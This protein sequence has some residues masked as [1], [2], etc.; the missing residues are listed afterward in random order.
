LDIDNEYKFDLNN[1]YNIEV[2]SY[3]YILTEEILSPIKKYT[4]IDKDG[5]FIDIRLS[6]LRDGNKPYIFSIA[7][8]HL[9]YNL[10]KKI[11]DSNLLFSNIDNKSIIVECTICGYKF[12]Y[13]TNNCN[14]KN[15]S[16]TRKS[17]ELSIE[18]YSKKISTKNKN[19]KVINIYNKNG[20]V[21]IDYI[22]QYCGLIEYGKQVSYLFKEEYVGCNNCKVER[23]RTSQSLNIESVKKNIKNINPNINILSETYKNARTLMKCECNICN[24]IWNPSYDSMR[25]GKGCPKCANENMVNDGGYNKTTAIRNKEAWKSIKSFVYVV[26]M[27]IG[28]DIFYK[29][30]IT[31]PNTIKRRFSALKNICDTMDILMIIEDNLFNSIFIEDDLHIMFKNKKY[32]PINK[33]SGWTECFSNIDLND[34][35]KYCDKN[36]LKYNLVS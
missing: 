35:Y 16:M 1:K 2:I 9:E 22:C 8:K 25:K 31:K 29:I 5:Y 34:I 11:K 14:C 21:L 12:K 19:N 17:P 30:G 26:K 20:K 4:V 28:N 13:I 33:F 36:T 3:G 18:Y 10:N 24:H 23:I 32:T 7:S 15:C 6:R 27:S